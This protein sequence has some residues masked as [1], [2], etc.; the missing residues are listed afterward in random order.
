[1]LRERVAI[2]KPTTYMNRSGNAL[3][4]LLDASD[5]DVA[6][7]MLVVVDDF[8]LPLGS[9][10]L[11]ARGS[12]GGHNGL[13]SIE[14]RLGSQEYGRLRIGVG[15]VTAEFPDPADFVL[16]PF[17]PEEVDILSELLPT[18]TEAVECWIKEGMEVAMNRHNRR[19]DAE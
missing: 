18:M 10:R 5:F 11:R 19:M 9:Y 2:V 8:Q 14:N 13:S 4:P 1:V 6:Q 3:G 15:P 16:S 7:E 17:E 12:A